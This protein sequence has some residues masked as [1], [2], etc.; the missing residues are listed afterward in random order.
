[1]FHR[2]ILK[3][4]D[5]LLDWHGML[6][7]RLCRVD[8]MTNEEIAEDLQSLGLH[9]ADPREARLQWMSVMSRITGF[10]S[11][12]LLHPPVM[13]RNLS[14]P[15]DTSISSALTTFLHSL[16][17]TM[18]S[19]AEPT[20]LSPS[21]RSFRDV[22]SDQVNVSP[23]PRTPR[24]V[25]RRATRSS[26]RREQRQQH[27][28]EDER[29]VISRRR[30]QIQRREESSLRTPRAT[31]LPY[32]IPLPDHVDPSPLL[33]E[34]KVEPEPAV[35]AATTT[36]IPPEQLNDEQPS[37]E[38]LFSALAQSPLWSIGLQT[39]HTSPELITRVLQTLQTASELGGGNNGSTTFSP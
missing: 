30:P 6:D 23:S 11:S 24:R 26:R 25:P 7:Y 3:I 9:Y 39:A 35:P 12:I 1:M 14:P 19:T 13:R 36:E 17:R 20:P 21:A 31:A 38:H 32:V 33:P 2:S 34:A 29:D 18:D 37:L 10:L 16:I 27:S 28:P 5:V 22:I 8:T 15:V 4:G